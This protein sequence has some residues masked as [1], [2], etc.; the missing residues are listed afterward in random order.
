V[1]VDTPPMVVVSTDPTPLPVTIYRAADLHVGG[2]PCKGFR[3]RT[4]GTSSTVTWAELARVLGPGR[5]T[6][7]D[8]GK[9]PDP[10]VAK[11]ARGGISLC[12]LD[13]GRRLASAFTGT[14]LLGLDLDHHGDVDQALRAWAPFRKMVFTTYRN[15]PTEPRC[16]VVLMLSETCSDASALRQG[17]QAV[18]QVAVNQGWFKA[19]DF[20]NAGADPTRLWFLPM[21]P[22]GSRYVFHVTD[23]A[24]LDLARLPAPP[25]PKQ[26]IRPR[27]SGGGDGSAA[28]A[29]AREIIR[30]T[31]HGG[32]HERMRNLALWLAR[33][34]S[35][36]ADAAIYD[37]LTI[38]ADDENEARE[39]HSAIAWGIKTGRAGR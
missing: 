6:V 37:A 38:P 14:R 35:I 7:G 23:G 11:S 29:R 13:G 32:R 25:P 17:H 22:P 39:F 31:P 1:T 26:S 24:L 33:D 20:D 4:T 16:R 27:S 36:S 21:I 2:D 19:G 3:P 15:T 5:C 8:P 10:K 12:G 30:E 34:V 28:I 9:Y 18:R